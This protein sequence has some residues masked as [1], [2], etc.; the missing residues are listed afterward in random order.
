[1]DESGT[2][3]AIEIG[4]LDNLASFLSRD[5]LQVLLER[6]ISDSQNLLGQL[7]SALDD[8]NPAEV[9]RLAH[10]LKSTSAN[11]GAIPMS[12]LAKRL[13]ALA[14]DEQLQDIRQQLNNLG[15]LFATT[16][17]ELRQLDFMQG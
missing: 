6:Y 9:T 15:Q 17:S 4:V 13:E 5:K 16:R 11:I 8:N 12:E 10:S 1:M 2:I 3:K 14:R 7:D